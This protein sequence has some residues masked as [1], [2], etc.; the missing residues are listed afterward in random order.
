MSSYSPSLGDIIYTGAT[1]TTERLS[2][3]GGFIAGCGEAA[4]LVVLNAVKGQGTSASDVTTLIKQAVNAGLVT[5]KLSGSGQSSPADLEALANAQGV[6]LQSGDYQSLLAQYAGTKPVIIGVSNARAFGGSDANVAGHYI[7]VVGRA[8][9][10]N[11]IVSDPNSP[12]SERGGF[13]TYSLAQIRAA[14]PFWSAVPQ[15]A[16][17]GGSGVNINPFSLQLPD[18]VNQLGARFTTFVDTFGG[19]ANPIRIFKFLLGSFI[20]IGVV[21]VIFA[22]GYVG[23]GRFGEKTAGRV[24][25]PAAETLEKAGNLIATNE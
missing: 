8:A 15:G 25:R 22:Y 13:V 10:G 16:V 3:V 11:Y 9:N 18:W 24:I 5:G 21:I 2:Q 20:L 12:D 17:L 7:T 6:G 23:A 14:L 4:L 1:A 19:W